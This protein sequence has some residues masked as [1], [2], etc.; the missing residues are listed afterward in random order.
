MT[1]R[2]EVRQR[3]WGLYGLADSGAGGGDPVRLGAALLEGGCRLIQLRCKG[4]SPEDTLRAAL[5]LGPRCRAVGATFLINDLAQLVIESGADGVHVGQT[6]G[7][8]D[9]IRAQIGPDRIL[10]RSTNALGALPQAVAQADYVAF[11]PVFSTQHTSRPRPVQGL[12]R[13]ARARAVVPE[14]VP[15]VA[16]GGITAGRLASVRS[17]GASAWAVIGAIAGADDPVA[18]TRALSA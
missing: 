7:D 9:T 15:L 18:A 10:G 12:E 1:P 11:G 2:D 16:I 3:V 8:T 4:W 17:A 5:Q 13:L 6:D 14:G